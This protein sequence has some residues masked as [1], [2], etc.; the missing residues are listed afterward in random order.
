[1]SSSDIRNCAAPDYCL[2]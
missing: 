1:L 2:E